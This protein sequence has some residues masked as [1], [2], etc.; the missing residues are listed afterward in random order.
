MK[1]VMPEVVPH[2]SDAPFLTMARFECG[3]GGNPHYHGFAVGKGNPRLE[4]IHEEPADVGIGDV[5]CD[6]HGDESAAETIGQ[7]A[8]DQS[9][10][11]KNL[12]N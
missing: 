9:L 1:M 3:D 5:G 12:G 10:H 11:E 6:L 4:R 2:S 8:D 7:D